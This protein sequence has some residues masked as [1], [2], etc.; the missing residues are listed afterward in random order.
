MMRP[1]AAALLLSVFLMTLSPAWAQTE[2][3]ASA[4][5]E[6]AAETDQKAAAR[7]AFKAAHAAYK[8][9]RYQEALDGFQAAY[10]ADPRPEMLYNI[11]LCQQKLDQL[12]AARDTFRRFVEEKP[13]SKSRP[14]VEKKIQEIEAELARRQKGDGDPPPPGD[15]S[16]PPVEPAP[17]IPPV[18]FNRTG[19]QLQVG[20]GI[21]ALTSTLVDS[22][23]ID[24]IAYTP[25]VGLDMAVQHRPL[26]F[27]SYGARITIAAVGVNTP[28]NVTVERSG[29]FLEGAV[30][31]EF[32]PLGIFLKE[33]RFDP[34][35][36][37]GVG[38]G[39]VSHDIDGT[40]SSIQGP[41]LHISAGMQVFLNRWISVGL[42]LSYM[43]PFWLSFCVDN[44]VTASCTDVPDLSQNEIDSLP[45]MFFVGA[46]GAF[47]LF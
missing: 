28:N 10:E 14:R 5:A 47:H 21:G 27:L 16:A 45:R 15:R 43:N 18:E 19:L 26:D 31:A 23:G 13:D 41:T 7:D 29:F 11:G 20:L 25:S 38:Y 1:F 42:V 39:Q 9:K 37:V 6:G 32:Y 33:S 3:D 40:K 17:P 4:P 34:F 35:I 44:Q 2:G 30:G 8:E 24:R 22:N 46:E 12:E 36:G